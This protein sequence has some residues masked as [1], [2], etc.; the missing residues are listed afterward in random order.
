MKG[1]F[2]VAKVDCTVEKAACQTYEIK[3]F[4]TVKLF[5]NGEVVPYSGARTIDAFVKFVEGN[6][7]I[8]GLSA[9][10]P[11]ALRSPEPAKEEAKPAADAAG[12][13]K[14]DVVVLTTSSFETEVPKGTWLVEFYAPWCGHCKRLAPTWEELAT[15]AKGKFNVAK[16]DCTVEKD[17]ASKHGIKGFPTIKMFHN[18]QATE[19]RGQRSVEDFMK[20]VEDT[21][22]K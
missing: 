9:S 16:V 7:P 12:G 11:E 18:G 21:L 13:E 17:L 4:P 14:S 15:K 3:G 19:Y 6:V 20:F 8:P 1:K 22:K 5:K 10:L 2:N